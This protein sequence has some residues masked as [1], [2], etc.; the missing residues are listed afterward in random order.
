MSPPRLLFELR[1]PACGLGL[2]FKLLRGV[3]RDLHL[4]LLGLGLGLLGQR[5]A[6][7][8]VGAGR[9]DLVGVD[10][11]RQREAADEAA[12][13]AL[14]AVEVLFLLLGLE[15]ALA[16]DGQG[17]AFDADVEV[18]AADAGNFE[19]EDDLLRVLVDIDGGEEVAGGQRLCGLVE[20]ALGTGKVVEDRVEAILQDRNIAQPTAERNKSS[21]RHCWYLLDSIKI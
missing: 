21:H 12:V 8:A 17:A 10:R 13:A 6:Q 14:D 15:L 11:G 9:V 3:R 4:D 20:L 16:L 19:L 7:H 1:F 18:L 2:R 5:D